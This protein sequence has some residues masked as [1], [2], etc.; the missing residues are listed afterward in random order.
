MNNVT[1]S[2]NNTSTGSENLKRR[3]LSFVYVT[4]M[5]FVLTVGFLGNVLC[6]IILRYRE[7]RRKLITPLMM[8]L[9]VADILIIV[10]VYPAMFITN[11]LGEPL[12]EGSLKCMWSSFANGAAGITSITTLVAMSGIMY[13]AI[14]Q[15]VPC[16]HIQSRHMILLVACT[17]L[18]GILI[19]LPPLIG[20]SRVVPGKAGISC[21]PEWTTSDPWAIAYIVFLLCFGF[22]LPL[23]LII[24]FHYLIYR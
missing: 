23:I 9:A 24:S 2:E 7:H 12:R 14:K 5:F 21:A 20:W 6:I 8:N 10:L 13:H 18:S 22:F 3:G 16:P 17:W 11:L 4:V 1:S 15:P 19:N